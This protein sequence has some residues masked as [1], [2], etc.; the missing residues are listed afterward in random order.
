MNGFCK[1]KVIRLPE[2]KG[3]GNAR[4]IAVEEAG[5]SLVAMMDSDDIC[6]PTRFKQQLEVF[7]QNATVDV[8]G[9]QIAEFCS[10][11]NHITGI[12]R[13]PVTDS[14]IKKYMKHRSPL[15]H[16]TVMA[17]REAIL[18]AGNYRS[19]LY[20]ED[21]YLWIRMSLNGCS[22]FNI[23]KILV[24]VRSGDDM[25]CR[26]GGI[27]YFQSSRKIQQFMLQKKVINYFEYIE[28]LFIRFVVHFLMPK[29]IRGLFYRRIRH[30]A[31]NVEENGSEM[32][33][34][35]KTEKYPKFSVAMS[36]Y[37]NDDPQFFEE[38]L[39]SVMEQSCLPDEIILV[40]DGEVSDALDFV[41][42]KYEC[43]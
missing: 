25:I 40:V 38:A 19:L 18:A 15:N 2:N 43:S 33:K 3:L 9:G 27:K 16:V 8:V 35:E 29:K 1:L 12:R 39:K 36:V 24:N 26:R 28:N 10:D 21:Y 5:N 6:V 4:K 37:K 22:F 20:N 7:Q 30:S 23:D 14:E 32:R 17:K 41:I 11:I 42:R 34:S 31:P 13:V